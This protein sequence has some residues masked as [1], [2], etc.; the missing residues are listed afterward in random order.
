MEATPEILMKAVD[1]AMQAVI[2][3]TDQKGHHKRNNK[4]LA[5]AQEENPEDGEEAG[6]NAVSVK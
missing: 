6:L 1:I 5:I 2:L 3:I 4:L